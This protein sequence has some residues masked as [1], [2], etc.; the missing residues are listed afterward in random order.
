MQINS[1][2]FRTVKSIECLSRDALPSFPQ[3]I[4]IDMTLLNADD[5]V[6]C[7]LFCNGQNKESKTL[8]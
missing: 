5:A 4:L 6:I 1:Y 2:F 8:I 3:M 7:V